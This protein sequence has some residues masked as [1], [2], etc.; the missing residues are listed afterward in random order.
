MELTKKYIDRIVSELDE[1]Y[2]LLRQE[3]LGKCFTNKTETPWSSCMDENR[4]KNNR[5]ID[6]LNL[7]LTLADFNSILTEIKKLK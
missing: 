5:Y 2:D 6:P 3:L 1:R 7:R 4:R